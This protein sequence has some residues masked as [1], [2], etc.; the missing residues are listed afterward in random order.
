[1]A[2]WEE[3]WLNW[4]VEELEKK[5]R[6]VKTSPNW[7]VWIDGLTGWTLFLLGLWASRDPRPAVLGGVGGRISDGVK[8]LQWIK[9]P[10]H[11]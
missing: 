6:N 3:E 4:I 8:E 10:S 5:P 9:W 1:V 7:I 2:P 11:C